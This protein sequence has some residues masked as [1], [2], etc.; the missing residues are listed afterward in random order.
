[1][2]L[3]FVEQALHFA[4]TG[5]LTNEKG[6]AAFG[7]LRDIVVLADEAQQLLDFTHETLSEFAEIIGMPAPARFMSDAEYQENGASLYE[8]ILEELQARRADEYRASFKESMDADIAGV[9]DR[10]MRMQEKLK[11]IPGAHVHNQ[12]RVQ[13]V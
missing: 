7:V 2:P 6:L 11:L 13:S 9:K 3:S 8:T 12:K 1:M 4:G 10:E 5:N